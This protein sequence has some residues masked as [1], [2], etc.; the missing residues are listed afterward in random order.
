[1]FGAI[2]VMLPPSDVAARV[3]M[4]PLSMRIRSPAA[5][6]MLPVFPAP[7]LS[8]LTLPPPRIS[9]WLPAL[10][11]IAPPAP[12]PVVLLSIVPPLAIVTSAPRR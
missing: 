9:T 6:V 1:M 8:A 12:A 5:I 3:E 7:R 10:R 4:L 11:L 2:S